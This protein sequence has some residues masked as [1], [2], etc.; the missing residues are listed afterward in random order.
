MLAGRIEPTDGC[1]KALLAVDGQPMARR[2]SRRSRSR[3]ADR[4]RG[5]RRPPA[6]SAHGLNVIDD[7]YPGEGPLGA[8]V[9]ALGIGLEPVV[10]VLACDLVAPSAPA[11]RALVSASRDHDA[12]GP[13]PGAG[14][15][16]FTPRHRE[17]RTTLL[18]AFRQGE[19]AIHRAAGALRVR[20]VAMTDDGPYRDAD[21]PAELGGQRRA[22]PDRRS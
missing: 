8:V 1:D 4:V 20:F 13:L 17:T 19:R 10:V 14:P 7:R 15:S 5:R 9:T 22:R 2:V 16:G 11:I 3:S 18:D 12:T 21:T 6:L